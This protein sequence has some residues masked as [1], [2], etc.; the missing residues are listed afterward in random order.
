MSTFVLVHG[1]WHG[2]W[3]WTKL[4]PLL[5]G[6]GHR[7]VTLDLPAHG[8]DR[9]PAADLTL[10][11]YVERVVEAIDAQHEPVV[12]VGHSMGGIVIT[13][14][15][16]QRPDKVAALVYL[17]A[18]LPRNGETLLQLAQTDTESLGLPNLVVSPDGSS[19]TIKDEAVRDMFYGECSDE[20]VRRARSLLC[21]DPFV[22]VTRPLSITDENFGRVPRYYI[23]CLRDRAVGPALQ[24]RMFTASP[25]R[26]VITMDTDH[27]PF[28]SAPEDLA[29]NLIGLG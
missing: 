20:D 7:A 6:F 4:V 3:C 19:T 27:S 13:Q 22:P 26:K 21:A 14:T 15:A 8:D 1:A 11:S 12:L 23:H 16:E 5:E 9:T 2:A 29:C 18:F 10:E 25:C 17:C 24:E 28:F